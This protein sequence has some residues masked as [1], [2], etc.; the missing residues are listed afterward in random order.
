[1]KNSILF[2]KR[3]GGQW[4]LYCEKIR[5]GNAISF[6]CILLR[7]KVYFQARATKTCNKFQAGFG[8]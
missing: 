8:L 7:S 3:K 1:M 2:V 5:V 6:S 4:L